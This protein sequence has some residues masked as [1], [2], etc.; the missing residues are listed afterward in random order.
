[1]VKQKGSSPE[2]K[3]KGRPKAPRAVPAV[4]T[5][6]LAAVG[7]SARK[8]VR[9]SQLGTWV[10]PEDRRD[11]VAVLVEQS[12]GRLTDLVPLRH[13]RMSASAFTFYRGAASLMANDLGT[14]ART[15]LI[16]QLAGDAHLANFG[17]FATAE[18]LL[19]FDL[20][21]F[22]ETLPGPVEWDV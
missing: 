4:R 5:P 14:H 9:R 11:P 7:R 22:D 20:N 6:E 15:G 3:A 1:M 10:A 19:V 17:G 18:R 16:V 12:E 8:E 21:D 13:A 2:Q